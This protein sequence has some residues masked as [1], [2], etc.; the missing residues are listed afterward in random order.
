MSLLPYLPY[1]KE[2]SQ[3]LNSEGKDESILLQGEALNDAQSW[4]EKI[5]H[6]TNIPGF[7]YASREFDQQEKERLKEEKDKFKF[8]FLAVRNIIVYL[9]VIFLFF[10]VD[11]YNKGRQIRSIISDSKIDFSSDRKLDSLVKLIR[12]NSAWRKRIWLNLGERDSVKEI[13][14]KTLSQAIYEIDEKNRFLRHKQ[15]VHFNNF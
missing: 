5:L 3:W 15:D 9:S 6:L 1:E 2:L 12:A 14:D 11:H 4:A 7:L 8:N 13:I 10:G